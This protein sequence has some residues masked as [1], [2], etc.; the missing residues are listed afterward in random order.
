MMKKITSLTSVALV[1]L[2]C[3]WLSPVHAMPIWSLDVTY[4]DGNIISGPISAGLR[5]LPTSVT[6][7]FVL[8]AGSPSVEPGIDTVYSLANV[9]SAEAEF[10]NATSTNL[11]NFSLGTLGGVPQALTYRFLPT[12][13]LPSCNGLEVANFPLRIIGDDIASGESFEYIYDNSTEVLSPFEPGQVPE[14]ASLLLG[15]T[16]VFGVIGLR[17]SRAR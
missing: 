9:F 13:C 15:L 1:A 6:V 12:T 14:P 11:L 8:T 5:A 10:G 17:R 4:T 16:G 7:N 3:F 2:A